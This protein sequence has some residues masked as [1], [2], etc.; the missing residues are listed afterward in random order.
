MTADVRRTPR[1]GTITSCV[2]HKA[3]ALHVQAQ[4]KSLYSRNMEDASFARSFDLHTLIL[5]MHRG[6]SLD[7]GAIELASR[8]GKP[9]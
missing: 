3:Y 9:G 6:A 7:G 1:R 5:A 2:R 8:L 4:V